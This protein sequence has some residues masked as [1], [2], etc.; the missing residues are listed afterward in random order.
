MCNRVCDYTS[1][2]L[3]LIINLNLTFGLLPKYCYRKHH[4]TLSKFYFYLTLSG[5]LLAKYYRHRVKQEEEEQQQQRLNAARQGLGLGQGFK[6]DVG[7]GPRLAPEPGQNGEDVAGQG[8]RQGLSQL[9]TPGPGIT[10]GQGLSVGDSGLGLASGPGPESTEED[11]LRALQAYLTMPDD[12]MTTD[13]SISSTMNTPSSSSSGMITSSSAADV[14]NTA[15]GTATGAGAATV[16]TSIDNGIPMT[17]ANAAD[18]VPVTATATG[19]ATG[20]GTTT[21]TA[22]GT[23]M[24]TTTGPGSG[25]SSGE[26]ERL[27]TLEKLM[28]LI[29]DPLGVQGLGLGLDIAQEQELGLGLGTAE[30]QEGDGVMAANN[31]NTVATATDPSS[32][33]TPVTPTPTPITP[34]TTANA[35]PTTPSSWLPRVPGFDKNNSDETN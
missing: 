35:V 7:Q 26:M 20:A 11:W 23:P 27:R 3:I 2:C 33:T 1:P 6:S 15:I 32:A 19:P 13:E 34:T 10:L 9:L 18:T 28:A 4:P 21:A 31:D 24:T 12:T 16:T 14:V 25:L 22:T 30:G 5:G 17:T 8:Q 29:G